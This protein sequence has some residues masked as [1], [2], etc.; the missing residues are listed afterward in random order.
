MKQLRLFDIGVNLTDHG[1]HKNKDDLGE[2]INRAMAMGVVGQLI[3]GGTLKE[4]RQA[5]K[6]AENYD[7]LYSTV[8]CHPT[9][10]NEMNDKYLDE[11]RQLLKSG[12]SKIKAIGELGLDYDRLHF[13]TKEKQLDGFEKQ[14]ELA[15]EFKLPLFLHDRNTGSDFYN[16][17]KKYR[18]S[19]KGGVVHSFTGTMEQMKRLVQ[20][21]L[22]IG[23]NGCSLKT[24]ENVE[25]VRQIPLDK[26]MLE[27]DCPWC[28]IKPSHYSFQFLEEKL[29][30]LKTFEVT[31]PSVNYPFPTF[32]FD[33]EF[34]VKP[35]KWEKHLMIKDRSEP[36]QILKVL[37]VVATVKQISIED[38]ATA[39]YNNTVNLLEIDN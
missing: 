4:S 30:E 35:K 13:C 39:S 21:D 17:I 1:F 8:G 11:L 3:T 38:L 32:V 20:L 22:F 36:G 5:L 14:L 12:T 7:G 34:T 24:K 37:C 23:I 2:I 16:I 9:R 28:T 31:H 26:I 19:I 25:V 27:T 33:K 15:K 29:Q 6:I 10:C 18:S